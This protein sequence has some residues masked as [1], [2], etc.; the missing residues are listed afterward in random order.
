MPRF[1]DQVVWIAGAS[2]GLGRAMALAFA[3]EG[4]H[5]AVSGRRQDRLDDALQEIL[6]I[7]RAETVRTSQ[8]RIQL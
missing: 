8:P 6:A 2:S 5:V 7:V 1:Q 3:R 4:A